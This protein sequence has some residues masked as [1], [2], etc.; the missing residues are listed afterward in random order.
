[1]WIERKLTPEKV[2]AVTALNLKGVYIQEEN[3]RFYP[4]AIWPRT[5]WV[6]SIRMKRAWAASSTSSTIRFAVKA[7]K[8]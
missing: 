3:Q 5:S 1:M 8:S 6:L 7:K 2:E 4:K